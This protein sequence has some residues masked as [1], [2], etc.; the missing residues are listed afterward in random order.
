MTPGPWHVS[1]AKQFSS[2]LYEPFAVFAVDHVTRDLP[3]I[4]MGRVAFT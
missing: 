4:A 1:V 2:R 3:E